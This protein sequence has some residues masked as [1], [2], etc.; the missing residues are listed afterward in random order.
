MGL[1]LSQPPLLTRRA[2]PPAR[3]RPRSLL[4]L[5]CLM[6][7]E[8]FK[9]KGIIDYNIQV[10]RNSLQDLLGKGERRPGGAGAGAGAR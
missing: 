8:N 10:F 1:L 2:L 4:A 3:A 5:V 9:K 7:E 6:R